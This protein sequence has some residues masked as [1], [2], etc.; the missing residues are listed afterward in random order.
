MNINVQG[1]SIDKQATRLAVVDCDIHP[2]MRANTDL[3]PFLSERW[4]NHMTTYG[5]FQRQ[6]LGDTLAYPRMTPDVARRDAW[7]P[8]G[9]PPGSDLEFMRKQHLDLNGVE[10]GILVPLRTGSGSQ[11][12]LEYGAALAHAMNDWQSAE[13]LDKEPRL[14][15]S[16]LCTP[17]D[18]VAAVKE[19]DHRA[20]DGRFVQVLI[21]PR[22]DEPL[23]R[24]RYWPIFEAAV[25]NNRPIGMHVGGVS[26][27]P[28]S[29]GSGAPSYYMEEHHSL[30]PAMQAVVT[31]MVLEGVFE[32]FPTLKV[33]LVEGSFAWSPA[34]SWRLDK[35]WKRMKD[36]VPHLKRK[37]SEYVHDHFWYTTQPIEEPDDPQ[38]LYKVMDWIGWD[39]LM[40]STDYPHWDFDDPRYVF[41]AKLDEKRRSMIFRDN[42]KALYGLV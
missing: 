24:R 22:T 26:G 11:R 42:A 17:E 6:A 29:A 27:H 21:P 18:P 31:S 10:V 20:Q 4:R 5:N 8:G 13:W 37:P 41:K 12:N 32:Q 25:R 39:H 40:F 2:Q 35:H 38:D 15:G 3:F 23:G 28:A 30:V 14:R 36:E 33:A 1:Q 7:P 9:A 19:I 34:L 16:I